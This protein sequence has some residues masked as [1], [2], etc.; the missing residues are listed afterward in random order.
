MKQ[1][2]NKLELFL[3][4]NIYE[5]ERKKRNLSEDE[6]YLEKIGEI[7]NKFPKTK[8]GKNF[9]PPNMA[10]KPTTDKPRIIYTGNQ[11]RIHGAQNQQRY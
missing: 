8:F 3:D 1:K 10:A 2:D 5:E 11:V 9:M 6:Y 7:A 4:I